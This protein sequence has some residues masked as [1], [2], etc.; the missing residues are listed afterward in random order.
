MKS[1]KHPNIIKYYKRFIDEKG[2]LCLVT[3]F[4]ENGDYESLLKKRFGTL[5]HTEE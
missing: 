2:M 1:I 3:E 4:C 5:E